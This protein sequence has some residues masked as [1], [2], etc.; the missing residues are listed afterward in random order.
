M[1]FVS[2]SL[3]TI[4]CLGLAACGT[5]KTDRT[6]S[7]AGIGAGVGALGAAATGGSIGGG[8]LL[9]GAVGAGTGYLTDADDIN[10]DN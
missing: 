4:A 3:A 8:A 2:L 9:G 10:L 5:N 7:G 6:V 1:K